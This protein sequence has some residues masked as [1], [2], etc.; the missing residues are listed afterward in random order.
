MTTDN[1]MDPEARPIGYERTILHLQRRIRILQTCLALALELLRDTYNHNGCDRQ[2][3]EE[4]IK[5][6]RPTETSNDE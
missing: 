1:G 5:N 2:R 6:V 3:I 4:M